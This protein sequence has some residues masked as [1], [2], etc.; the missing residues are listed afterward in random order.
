MS[1]YS[2]IVKQRVFPL[3]KS[4]QIKFLFHWLFLSIS[5][6]LRLSVYLIIRQAA[7]PLPDG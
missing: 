3:N 5:I 1:T 6:D 2:R 4:K 7:G